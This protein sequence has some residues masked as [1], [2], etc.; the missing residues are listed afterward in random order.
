MDPRRSVVRPLVGVVVAV[1]LAA[2]AVVVTPGS[3]AGAAGDA[4]W[5]S[6]AAG[7]RRALVT[8]T[9][10]SVART[11]HPVEVV[12]SSWGAFPANSLRVVEVDGTGAVTDAAVPF[13]HDTIAGTPTLTFL[14]PGTTAAGATRRFYAYFDP[15]G[16]TTSIPAPSFTDRV[17]VSNS[18]DE[19]QSS[20]LV[21]SAGGSYQVQKLGGAISSLLDGNGNDWVSYN[22]SAGANGEYRGIPNFKCCAGYSN[23]HPG[24]ANASTTVVADGP[25]RA[26]LQMT[27]TAGASFTY[28]LHVFPRFVR[29]DVTQAGASYWLLYEGTPGGED[30]SRWSRP[31]DVTR[32]D[33]TATGA[34]ASSTTSWDSISVQWDVQWAYFTAKSPSSS[35]GRAFFMA[36]NGASGAVNRYYG[37]GSSGGPTESEPVAMTVFGFGRAGDNPDGAKLTTPQTWFMGLMDP[38]SATD[39]VAR[40]DAARRPVSVTVGSVET[41]PGGGATVPGAPRSP[42][43]T[44]SG[45]RSV[46]VSWSAPADDGGS[47]VLDYTVAVLANGSPTGASSTTGSTSASFSGLTRGVAYSFRVTARNAVGSG[48]AATSNAVT[49]PVVVPGAP[50]SPTA[51]LVSSSA[52]GATVTVSWSAPADDGGSSI[53]GYDVSASPSGGSRTTSAGS[54]STTFTGLPVGFVYRFSVAARNSIGA[55]PTATV[56]LDVPAVL[57]GAVSPDYV[58]SSGT[59]R[60]DSRV[61]S[62]VGR[63][64]AGSVWAFRPP[65]TPLDAEAA[66]LNVTA[67][68]SGGPGYLTLYPCGTT[69]PTASTLNLLP[70]TDV[71]NLAVVPLG[72]DGTVCLFAS[73]ATHVVIDAVGYV[74]SGSSFQAVQP[75]RL[76]ETRVR[77]GQIGYT[78]PTP[79]AGQR[80]TLQVTGRATPAVPAGAAAVVLNVTGVD[81]TADGYVTVWPCDPVAPTTS[82]LNLV[83]GGTR[84]NLM[85][86]KPS[87]DGTVCLITQSGSELIVDIAGWFPAATA[88]VGIRPERLLDTRSGLGG[89]RPGDAGTVML[90]V[91]GAGAQPVPASAT[92]VVLNLTGTAASAAG[93]VTAYPC[94]AAERP[95]SSNLNVV[96]GVITPNAAIVPLDGTGRVCLYASRA[97]DLVVDVAGW[98]GPGDV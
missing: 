23:F 72:A 73:A 92:A 54:T 80:I 4:W 61:L 42:S 65:A 93:F 10:S 96:P 68:E 19:G 36:Q 12:T 94:G 67:T 30:G 3:S 28:Y 49:P 41:K 74:V 98:F 27:S 51:T 53:T 15:P 24:F 91:V 71:P 55:G 11:D 57:D 86:A 82:T 25:V 20:F 81:A 77:E 70:G 83:R 52:A 46:S 40:I 29:G 60:L 66:V 87:P 1:A 76:L 84:A 35:A 22:A 43:A 33:G 2:L 5:S 50:G 26:T 7:S 14:A 39:A 88:Y 32:D 44:L 56:T 9:A 85:I 47:S 37:A 16:S 62:D 78:G 38:T 21:A 90:T 69:P 48:S 31:F 63:R 95:G 75:E 59:N 18:Y 89:T 13:Q 17:A 8:M 58:P 79:V 6:S 45:A 97:V 64:A 34:T